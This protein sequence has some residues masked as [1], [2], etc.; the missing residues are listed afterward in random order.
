MRLFGATA[1]LLIA[2]G[3]TSLAHAQDAALAAAIAESAPAEEL[4]AAEV[5][6]RVQTDLASLGP[7]SVGQPY[8]GALL[9]G[10]QMQNGSHWHVQ[11]PATGFAT[12]ETIDGI[13]RVSEIVERQFPGS[14][15]LFVGDIAREGG[16]HLRP[17]ASHQSGRDVDLS[18]YY[19]PGY[20][21]WYQPA[22]I[23]TLDRARSWALVRA[24][25]TECDVEAI[26]I[27]MRVQRLLYEHALSIGEDRVWLDSLFGFI[28]RANDPIV[29]HEFGHQTHLHVRF[30]NPRAQRLGRLAY[31]ALVTRRLIK[32]RQYVA[33]HRAFG[34][35]SMAPPVSIP[36][37]RLPPVK[38][39]EVSPDEPIAV[40]PAPNAGSS[41]AARGEWGGS[42]VAA[43][44]TH[45][46]PSR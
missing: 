38:P 34:Q 9:N 37:R 2:M 25:I 32:P 41:R 27:D 26:F 13:I 17:H 36:P 4:T 8:A 1:A 3:M 19:K 45:L 35:V 10:V 24:L 16:G 15:K 46:A 6:H 33:K 22:S 5:A 31:D 40:V 21:A 29:K 42:P 20:Q 12:Q 43:G 23:Y 18:Y 14:H 28:R 11:Q 44:P 30:Y 39:P 7:M